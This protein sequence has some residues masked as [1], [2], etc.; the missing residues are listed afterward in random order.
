MAE[1]APQSDTTVDRIQRLLEQDG[2]SQQDVSRETSHPGETEPE[3]AEVADDSGDD[4]QPEP[5]AQTEGDESEPAPIK[6]LGDLAKRLE[7]EEEA[8]A[9]HLTV[10]GADGKEVSL[11]DVLTSYR[12]PKP[13][14][15][16]IERSRA[17]LQELEAG[18]QARNEAIREMAA[19]AQGLAQRMKAQQPD[20]AALKAGDPARY[21]A[22]R[23]EWMEHERQL[24]LADRQI[25]AQMQQM[26]AEQAR[27]VEA[28]RREQA[29]KLRAAVPAWSD[30]KVMQSDL[31]SVSAWLVSQG[32]SEDEVG[33]LTDHRDW[34]IARKA[35]LYDQIQAKKPA[36][37]EKI[38][39]LPKVIA[40]G[41]SN[42]AD[43]GTAA[44]AARESEQLAARAKETGRVEDAAA[45]IAHRLAG[46]A[47][48]AAGRTLASGRRA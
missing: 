6:S 47:R 12:A 28:F 31:E 16:E 10:L 44:R 25:Q 37:I 41:A 20:W 2:A 42:G 29:Q 35:M 34:L 4:Y 40:P 5:N 46:S 26:Q 19:A 32:I 1:T 17:R 7:M 48:R 33:N 30:T 9:K 23:M 36:V 22:A 11:H 38:K 27:K 8:L 13:E 45:A 3:P 15:A 43:R 18:E 24:E 14:L 39:Q 21:M